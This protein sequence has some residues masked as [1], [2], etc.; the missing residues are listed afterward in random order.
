MGLRTFFR[1]IKNK[2]KDKDVVEDIPATPPKPEEEPKPP[3]R[4]KTLQRL[5]SEPIIRVEEEPRGGYE[6]EGGV[7]LVVSES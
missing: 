1:K 3:P 5:D 7:L 2:L 6:V 4:A